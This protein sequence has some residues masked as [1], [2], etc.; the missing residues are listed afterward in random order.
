VPHRR[1]GR[2]LHQ[3]RSHVRRTDQALPQQPT[4]AAGRSEVPPLTWTA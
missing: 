4:G 1:P 2:R 3:C